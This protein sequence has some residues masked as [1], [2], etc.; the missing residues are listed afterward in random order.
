MSWCGS[1]CLLGCSNTKTLMFDINILLGL[2]SARNIYNPT[3][4]FTSPISPRDTIIA[5]IYI[6]SSRTCLC[7]QSAHVSF[8]V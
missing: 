6:E 3:H 2:M 7:L 1:T 4:R 8:T 5:H